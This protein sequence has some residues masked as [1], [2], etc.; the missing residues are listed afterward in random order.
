[1]DALMTNWKTSL[2]GLGPFLIGLVEVGAAA[3]KLAHID[4]P[5]VQVTG[6][7]WEMM[8]NGGPL[9]SAG[10]VGFMA[11]DWNKSSEQSGV[12]TESK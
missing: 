10:L 12:K 1:M 7:P 2:A 9:L 11:R 8:V 6:D 4:I 3:A 5:G